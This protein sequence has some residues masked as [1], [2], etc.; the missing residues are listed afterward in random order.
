MEKSLSSW[1]QALVYLFCGVIGTAGGGAGSLYIQGQNDQKVESRLTSLE[2]NKVSE[3][4][5]QKMEGLIINIAVDICKLKS[6]KDAA[7][8]S[9]CEQIRYNYYNKP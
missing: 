2:N 1:K 6:T 9:H 7:A 5:F 3:K 4:E 8:E